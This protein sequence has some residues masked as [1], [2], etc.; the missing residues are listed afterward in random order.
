MVQLAVYG[1]RNEGEVI[2]PSHGVVGTGRWPQMSRR[3][4]LSSSMAVPFR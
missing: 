4:P 2:N 3:T 1:D